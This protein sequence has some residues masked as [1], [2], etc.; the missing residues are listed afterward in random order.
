MYIWRD[1]RPDGTPPNNW[2]DNTVRSAWEWDE[3]AGQYYYH[4]FLQC[5]PDLNYRNPAVQEAMN[6][7][8]GFWLDRGVDG[9]RIDAATHLLEDELLRDEPTPAGGGKVTWSDRT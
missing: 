6:S 1:G 9:F 7:V 3:V 2:K 4:R 5:Q 8:L